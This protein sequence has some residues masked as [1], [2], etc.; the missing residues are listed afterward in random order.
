MIDAV[1][2]HGDQK[3]LAERMAAYEAAGVAELAFLPVGVGADP[4]ASVQR[5]WEVLAEL[6]PKAC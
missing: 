6:V 1:V 3:A 5:T 2:P 4:A